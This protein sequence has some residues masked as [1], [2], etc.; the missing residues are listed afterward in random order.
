MFVSEKRFC[1][2]LCILKLLCRTM[3][4]SAEGFRSRTA[5]EIS[6][7]CGFGTSAVVVVACWDPRTWVAAV[8]E[9]LHQG[10]CPVGDTFLVIGGPPTATFVTAGHR[11]PPG[12]R[13]V[14]IYECS[15]PYCPY[16]LGGFPQR[17]CNRR[18]PWWLSAPSDVGL[19]V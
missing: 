8:G 13:G 18:I 1:W 14:S 7:A 15:L 4:T 17:G 10:F 6:T 11:P 19:R 3:A 2:I 16:R 12:V 5:L 9:L